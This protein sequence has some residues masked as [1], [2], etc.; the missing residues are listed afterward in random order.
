[1]ANEQLKTLIKQG[2]AAMKAGGKVA[3]EAADD[4]QNDASNQEL[5][6]MLG[7]GTETSKKWHDRIENA[8]KEVGGIEEQRNEIMEAHYKVSKEIRKQAPDDYSRDLGIIAN[9]QMV[10]HY[11]IA[12]F[13]TMHAYTKQ[14]GMDQVAED[15]KKCTQEAKRADEQH[16]EL[17]MNI[18][19]QRKT[20]GPTA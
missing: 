1:M 12:V 6:Q 17:A 20:A 8:L 7:R 9:G 5:K 14:V 18:M 19:K 13:G 2:L 3:K 16:T 11:W 4:I 10:L 15:M